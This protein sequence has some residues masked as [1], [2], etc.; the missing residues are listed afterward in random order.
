MKKISITF[1]AVSI[2]FTTTIFAQNDNNIDEHGVAIEIPEV[3]LVDVEGLDRNI[4]LTPQAPKE[5]GEFLDFSD[6]T[7][8]SLWLNYSSVVGSKTEAS[9]KVTVAITNGEVPGGMDLYVAA[10][11]IGSGKGQRGVAAGKVKLT[12]IATDL[13][14]G[15]GTCY[16][17]NGVEKGR[18][19]TYGLQLASDEDAVS[20]IDFD[21]A[22]TL[23]I[24]YTL[25]DN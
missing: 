14:N 25:T 1:A 3:A 11:G 9:R 13:V 20:S 24:T 6:A 2:I 15:I 12:D 18:Q 7:D 5:A 4:T 19:L 23:T 16:T 10:G 22:T 21:D 8:N 17:E